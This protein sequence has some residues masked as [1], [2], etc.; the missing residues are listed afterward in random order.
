[1]IISHVPNLEALKAI[2]PMALV[3]GDEGDE[4]SE[5]QRWL[6]G[7]RTPLLKSEGASLCF[8]SHKPDGIDALL[9]SFPGLVEFY[10]VEQLTGNPTRQAR[11]EDGNLLWDYVDDVEIS[12]TVTS[13]VT[14]TVEVMVLEKQITPGWEMRLEQNRKDINEDGIP[15]KFS[16]GCHDVW[17]FIGETT[18]D[19]DGNE[20]FP[21]RYT[22]VE[23]GSGEYRDIIEE[24]ATLTETPTVMR[25]PM[26]DPLEPDPDVVALYAT[27]WPRTPGDEGNIPPFLHGRIA[28]HW[29]PNY[30]R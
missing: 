2:P 8:L 5:L 22:M 24:T 29:V 30:A 14:G 9:Q 19:D 23:V 18:T 15:D 20:L 25:V 6:D 3:A 13:T 11:D 1:M 12:R 27:F 16:E 28:G 4:S 10:A 26:L 17:E 7:H 21:P